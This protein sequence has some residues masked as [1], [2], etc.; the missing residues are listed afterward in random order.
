[1]RIEPSSGATILP[2]GSAMVTPRAGN[3]SAGSPGE[4]NE[5][6][7]QCAGADFVCAGPDFF[8]MGAEF[9]P[10]GP[11][12]SPTGADFFPAGADF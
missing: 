10:K 6:A 4:P 3:D 11:G 9:S 12:F 7:I 5:R 1:M 8:P 2:L